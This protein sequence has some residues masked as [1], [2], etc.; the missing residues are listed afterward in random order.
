MKHKDSK[1]DLIIEKAADFFYEYGY[2]KSTL[3]DI[4][5]ACGITHPTIYKHFKNKEALAQHFIQN[6]FHV[7]NECVSLFSEQFSAE[8][9]FLYYWLLHFSIIFYDTKFARFFYEYLKNC[10]DEF[11]ELESHNTLSATRRLLSLDAF[12]EC[13][14][15]NLELINSSGAKLGEYCMNGKI[16]QYQA[17]IYM[18]K[19]MNVLNNNRFHISDKDILNFATVHPDAV[20]YTKYDMLTNQLGVFRN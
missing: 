15:L 7:C 4:T 10:P 6:Y 12:M 16:N 13:L 19:I 1:K 17:T 9:A 2:V 20:I 3:R 5:S 14:D 11:L 18:T 8:E